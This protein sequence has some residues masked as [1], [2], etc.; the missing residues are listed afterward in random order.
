MLPY[1]F[2]SYIKSPIW[3]NMLSK[4]KFEMSKNSWLGSI[5]YQW[6]KSSRKKILIIIIIIMITTLKYSKYYC[7]RNWEPSYSIIF[8]FFLIFVFNFDFLIASKPKPRQFLLWLKKIVLPHRIYCFNFFQIDGV[9]QYHFQF[10]ELF[11]VIL[12]RTNY[13]Q[14]LKFCVRYYFGTPYKLLDN[15]IR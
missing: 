14:N 15:T 10:F 4:F 6:E 12:T 9:K 5:A 3:K 13:S 1:Y 2:A 7:T 8:F 11:S